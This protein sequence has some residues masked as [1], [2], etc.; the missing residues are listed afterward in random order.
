MHVLQTMQ[1]SILPKIRQDR[2][3]MTQDL[4]ICWA[5]M[6]RSKLAKEIATRYARNTGM[7]N[8][9][10][11]NCGMNEIQFYGAW[12]KSAERIFV[13]E[14]RFKEELADKYKIKRD[15]IFVLDVTGELERERDDVKAELEG[16][17]RMY[18]TA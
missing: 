17:L 18:F 6:I 11:K 1:L 5:G 15:K 8:Y 16:K 2:L 3:K 7:Q 12:L 9:Q 4:F 10:A 14:D 13:M